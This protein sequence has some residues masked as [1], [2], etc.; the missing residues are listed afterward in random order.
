VGSQTNCEPESTRVLLAGT[1]GLLGEIIMEA[2]RTERDIEIVGQLDSL[3]ELPD[4][5]R[6]AS[7]DVIVCGLPVAA[8]PGLFDELL[9]ANPRATVV[10]IEADGRRGAVYRMRPQRSPM[11]ELSPR[12]LLE[13]IRASRTCR[14]I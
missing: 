14:A 12:E 13:V 4:A 8:L 5:T 3:D 10:A 2:A 11:G 7:V 1:R 6:L 9:T